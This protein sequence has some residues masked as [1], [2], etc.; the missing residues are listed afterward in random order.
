[1][2]KKDGLKLIISIEIIK[3]ICQFT[4][5]STNRIKMN[6]MTGII[7]MI[8]GSVLLLSSFII[9]KQ[10]SKAEKQIVD[11]VDEEYVTIMN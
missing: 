10:P 1:M 2:C 4:L 5:N 6:K 9:F 3:F 7:L 11:L 8:A